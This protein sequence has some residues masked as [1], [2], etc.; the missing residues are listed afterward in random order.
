MN[1]AFYNGASG[2]SAYQ[3]DMDRIS[4][5]IAN[6]NTTGYKP[7]RS[8]FSDLLYSQMAVNTSEDFLM[9]HGT[10]VAS[11][12]LIFTQGAVIPTNNEMDFG[13]IGSGFFAVE[14]AE[15]N[16]EYTR[17]GAF[18]INVEDGNLVT[19]DGMY[20][21]DNEGEILELNIDQHS[22]TYILD[23]IQ[24]R[25]GVFQ[26]LNP[27]GLMQ[28]EGGRYLET[29]KSGEAIEPD[30]GLEQS[31]SIIK[32]ALENSAVDLSQEM[33]NVITSQKAYQFS[34][35]IVQTADQLEEIV[36]NLR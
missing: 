20:V 18:N 13:I 5:N 19:N 25:L 35:R 27:Y 12:D 6:V 29:E 15:G 11:N 21:L 34:A 22:G 7:S 9:G 8:V 36:N 33:V 31:Y 3:S 1:I 14:D 23:D 32:S 24:H 30:Y 4:H 16:R 26:F 2:L 17:N 10:K 28:A